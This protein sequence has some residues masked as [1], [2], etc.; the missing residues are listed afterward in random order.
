MASQN[1]PVLCTNKVFHIGLKAGFEKCNGLGDK[2]KK[3][4]ALKML[5]FT[6]A[7]K[8]GFVFS[9]PTHSLAQEITAFGPSA[10]QEVPV[11][12]HRIPEEHELSFP[13]CL[14]HQSL[15]TSHAGLETRIPA[16]SAKWKP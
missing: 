13:P 8:R 6:F 2:K 7:K 1:A 15:L 4:S 3:I 11:T 9:T 5:A 12:K 14:H 16:P 10:C